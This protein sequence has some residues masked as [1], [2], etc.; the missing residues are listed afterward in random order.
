M[1]I[2]P[3]AIL[4]LFIV[5]CNNS[6]STDPNVIVDRAI[7]AHGL[8]GLVG[9]S[10][11]FD[12]RDRHYKT[13]RY[14]DKFVYY[15]SWE[16][17]L[18]LVIDKL[19]N[20]SEFSRKLNDSTVEVNAEWSQRYGNSVNSV[21]YFFQLPFGLNDPAVNKTYIGE[22]SINQE[23]YQIVKV[24][25]QQENGGEDFQDEYFYWIHKEKYT[26]DFLAYNYITDGGGVRFRQ[27]INRRDVNGLIFQDYVNYKPL[28]KDTPLDSLDNLFENGELKKLSLILS[29]N[30]E[31]SNL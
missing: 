31:V 26:V 6:N 24:T 1:R 27:A 11:E 30:I 10:V 16:D 23:P 13:E 4:I 18:G 20:S 21:L 3:L 15:R 2:A 14:S 17:S 12:F 7:K 9:K 19:V 22:S 5:G 29:E 25:F 8:D 28:S